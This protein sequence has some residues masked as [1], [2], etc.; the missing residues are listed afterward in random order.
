MKK[1]TSGHGYGHAILS[2]PHFLIV[3]LPQG[4]RAGLAQGWTSAEY[5]TAVQAVDKAMSSV[6]D[7]YK[8]MGLLPKTAVMVAGLSAYGSTGAAPAQGLPWIASG[9]GIK[10]HHTIGQ[11]VSI[12][13]TGAT[14]MRAFGL[15]THTEW[16]SRPI[17]DIFVAPRVAQAM[18]AVQ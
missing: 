10:G 11:P 17:E 15:T 8:D 5:R 1:A 7:L 18:P 4:A 16:D 13:D 2:L 3:H 9:P 12:I 14:V 6:L